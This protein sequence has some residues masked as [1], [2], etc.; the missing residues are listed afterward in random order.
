MK[1]KFNQ[2]YIAIPIKD[3]P[4]LTLINSLNEHKKFFHMT[5][6]FLGEID[7]SELDFVR[8]IINKKPEHLKNFKL[9]PEKFD[10]IGIHSKTHVLRIKE[11]DDI[12]EF[13]IFLEE[14]LPNFKKI[15][16]PF[17]PHVTIKSYDQLK[18]PVSTLNGK[19]D[20]T[21]APYETK[22]IGVYYKTEEGATALL[23]S[24]KIK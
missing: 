11:T 19:L 16:L 21:I 7:E 15:N 22:S 1:E 2:A 12:F 6:Y 9:I 8:E 18:V 13:R 23:Y 3:S 24:H 14:N 5:F 10:M 17:Q 4:L 20:R